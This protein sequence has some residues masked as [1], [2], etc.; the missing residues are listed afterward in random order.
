MEKMKQQLRITGPVLI[1]IGGI[2]LV[3]GLVSF[4][5]S[6]G[7]HL[8]P[9]NFWCAFIGL[10][11]VGFGVVVTKLAFLKPI[12]NYFEN[13]TRDAVGN[14]AKN[15]SHNLNMPGTDSEIVRC[16]KCNAPNKSSA[17]F[18]NECGSSIQKSVSCKH[19]SELNDADAIFC[20]NCGNRL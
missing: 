15:I 10:P 6:F 14:V 16:L 18:C 2:F 13:E 11:M 8:P 3:V 17:K 20:D 12:S 19:C 1:F 9:K 7:T 5:S 4:F